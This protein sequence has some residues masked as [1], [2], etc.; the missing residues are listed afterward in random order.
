MLPLRDIVVFPHMI[1]AL[2][3]GSLDLLDPQRK[4]EIIDITAKL[5]EGMGETEKETW[6]SLPHASFDT[7]LMNPPFTRSTGQEGEKDWH[8]AAHVR[9]LPLNEGRTKVNG[10]SDG[11][12]HR[13]HKRAR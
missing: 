6:L 1:A 7:V 10:A 9:G 12:A 8:P 5:I 2:P 11:K 13:R 3:L 4:F